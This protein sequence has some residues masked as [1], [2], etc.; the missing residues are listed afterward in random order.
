MRFGTR[1][2]S[3]ALMNVGGS[4]REGMD[5]VLL[6]RVAAVGDR[7]ENAIRPRVLLSHAKWYA[8]IAA[9]LGVDG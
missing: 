5:P 8:E 9:K 6:P 2:Y 4:V 1:G 7:P 3:S